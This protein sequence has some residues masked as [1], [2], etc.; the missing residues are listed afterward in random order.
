[1]ELKFLELARFRASPPAAPVFEGPAQVRAYWEG[2]RKGA[3]IPARWALDPRGMTGALDR[4]FLAERIGRGVAQVRIAGSALGEIAGMDLRGL[5]LT[6]LFCAETRDLV[7]QVLEQVVLEPAIAELDLISDRGNG[8]VIAQLVLMPLADEQ[9]RKLILGAFGFAPAAARRCKFK[10]ARRRE[11][12]LN[13]AAVA[14]A[15][16]PAP[17]PTARRYGHLTLVHFKD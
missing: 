4:V 14:V 17:E 7:G 16:V 13:P 2:L 12:R 6:C 5:P 3:A 11:E 1:M 9:D 10:V 15:P 8:D